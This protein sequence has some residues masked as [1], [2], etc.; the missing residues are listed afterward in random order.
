MGCLVPI[1]RVREKE[2]ARLIDN[3]LR[4]GSPLQARKYS[5]GTM[6]T[7][8][9]QVRR[10]LCWTLVDEN[11]ENVEQVSLEAEIQRELG[12]SV[13]ECVFLEYP[14]AFL[15]KHSI[16]SVSKRADSPL[17]PYRDRIEAFPEEFILVG[18]A[19][20]Q[21]RSD[22]FVICLTTDAQSA[23]IQRNRRIS[24]DIARRSLRQIEKTAGTWNILEE[25][26]RFSQHWSSRS[27]FEIEI[28]LPSASL[29]RDSRFGERSS[30]DARD[31][32]MEI[33]SRERENSTIFRRRVSEFVQTR[34]P[35]RERWVQT[36]PG[37]P[38]NSWTQYVY[39]DTLG[40]RVAEARDEVE[41]RETSGHVKRDLEDTSDRSKSSLDHDDVESEKKKSS[42]DGETVEEKEDT[43]NNDHLIL[44]LKTQEQRVLDVA[45]YNT[46]INPDIDDFKKWAEGYSETISYNTKVNFLE[47]YCF[48]DINLTMNK[49][50]SD[51]SWHPV[52]GGLIA[53]SY[54]DPGDVTTSSKPNEIRGKSLESGILIWSTSDLLRPKYSLDDLGSFNSVS[55]CPSIGDIVVGGNSY[56]QIVLWS[57]DTAGSSNVDRSESSDP[58]VESRSP[59]VPVVRPIIMSSKEHSHRSSVR[60]IQW[61]PENYRIESSGKLKKLMDETSLQFMSIGDDGTLRIW[62]LSWCPA[63]N[64][65]KDIRDGPELIKNLKDLEEMQAIFQLRLRNEQGSKLSILCVCLP[66]PMALFEEDAQPRGTVELDSKEEA[67]MRR[68]WVGVAEGE[69]LCCTWEDQLLG[70]RRDCVLL[71]SSHCHDGPVA[72]IARSPH[73]HDVFLAIGGHVLSIWKDDYLDSPVFSRRTQSVYTSCCWSNKPGVF[74]VSTCRG[75]IEVWD[76]RRRSKGPLVVE[77]VSRGALTG[78]YPSGASAGNDRV[79]GVCDC[80]GVF[81]VLEEVQWWDDDMI[82]RMD[83]FEEFLW[84]EVRRKRVFFAWQKNLLENDA[85]VVAKRTARDAE[86]RRQKQRAA[87]DI[88]QKEHEERLLMER[89]KALRDAAPKSKEDIY[90]SRELRRMKR[91]LLKKKGLDPRDIEA[92][93]LPMLRLREERSLKMTKARNEVVLRNV[94][95]RDALAIH[96]PELEETVAATKNTVQATDSYFLMLDKIGEKCKE[97]FLQI[98]KEARESLKENSGLAE[99]AK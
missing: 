33:V 38:K 40:N 3:S 91:V 9:V 71:S 19:S 26:L 21:L 15:P 39:E 7:R 11:I 99:E 85:E 46:V 65:F 16:C 12:C 88:L 43:S 72:N 96:F 34:L 47:G 41:D 37:N 78:M 8:R 77:N 56:G 22:R 86:Q 52:H 44:F 92:R 50:V 4:R 53:V 55:F 80:N 67:Y 30:G 17:E 14:W 58:S 13:G 48:I 42:T 35:P 24:R 2:K 81:R 27:F 54:L 36:Y 20:L 66:A 31:S 74:L 73:F 5:L 76:I 45:R 57:L 98:A 95:Y 84:R 64:T 29:R 61:L 93:R 79:F 28:S 97:E 49:V 10:E 32:C 69:L 18:Y 83:W 87:R 51:V 63:T 25:H 70:T 94:Y 75:E 1:G 6:S 90:R 59:G 89:K 23:V 82:G 60:Q 68:V 62:D